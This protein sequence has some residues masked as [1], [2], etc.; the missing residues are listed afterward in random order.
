MTTA[1]NDDLSDPLG[2]RDN[3]AKDDK[4]SDLLD[5]RDDDGKDDDLSDLWVFDTTTA[6][7]D[8]LSDPL[9]VRDDEAKDD[10]PS[11]LLGVR[12]DNS[13]DDEPSDLALRLRHMLGSA[14]PPKGCL[15]PQS[16]RTF[17]CSRRRRR[18]MTT[19][20]GVRYDNR[21]RRQTI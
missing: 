19:P 16:G 9:G 4:P 15:R 18:T 5:V 10:E 2:V 6:K 11:D 8:D 12:Y 20:F 21:E 1:K 14:Q 13:K 3:E 17:G 7:N